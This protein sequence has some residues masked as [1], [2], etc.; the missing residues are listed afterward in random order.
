MARLRRV[1]YHERMI[2]YALAKELEDAGF[3]HDGAGYREIMPGAFNATEHNTAYVPSLAELIQA[4]G[5]RELSIEKKGS[6]V[7]GE[8][9]WRIWIPYTEYAASGPTLEVA[10]ARLWLALNKPA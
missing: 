5:D 10:T 2:D 1:W 3:P 7:N 4:L 8:Y 6:A 9:E